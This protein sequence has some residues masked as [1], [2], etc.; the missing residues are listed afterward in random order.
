MVGYPT[1]DRTA[2]ARA[3]PP[4]RRRSPGAAPVLMVDSVAHLDLIE[5]AA[6]DGSAP[7]RVAIELDVGYWPLGGPAEDRAEALADP[8]AAPGGRAGA[9]DRRTAAAAPGRA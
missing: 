8:H 2:I 7:I 6:G 9:G 3:G 1:A 5:D 4:D